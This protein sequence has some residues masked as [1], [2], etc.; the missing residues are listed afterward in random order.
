MPI[1]RWDD[2]PIIQGKQAEEA[3]LNAWKD[4][5]D[6]THLFTSVRRAT[7]HE[8]L[9]EKTD[10]V[11]LTK[12]GEILRIQIKSYILTTQD[13]LKLIRYGVI[14]ITIKAC[15]SPIRIRNKTFKAIEQFQ[16]MQNSREPPS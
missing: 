15:N 9:H 12:K 8:D 10:V 7:E 1:K 2:D 6:F 5:K 13:R 16:K 4:L 11:M 14:P 3:F